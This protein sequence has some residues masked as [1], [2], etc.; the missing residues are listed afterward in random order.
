MLGL[1]HVPIAAISAC[2]QRLVRQQ[3]DPIESDTR[4]M[5]ELVGGM[6]SQLC[7]SQKGWHLVRV[8]LQVAPFRRSE[9][10]ANVQLSGRS[11]EM[12]RIASLLHG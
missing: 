5:H 1:L 8:V 12:Q 9:E 7:V 11:S 6:R 3:G 4:H 10:L 2:E